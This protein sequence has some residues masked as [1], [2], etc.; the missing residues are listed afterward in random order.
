MSNINSTNVAE[1]V[2]EHLGVD[3]SETGLDVCTVLKKEGR[4]VITAEVWGGKEYL[5]E[6]E[7]TEVE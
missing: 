3:V 5:I 4:L 6:I 1:S 7:V 2:L